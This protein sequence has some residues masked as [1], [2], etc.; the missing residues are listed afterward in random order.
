MDR[1]V[2]KNVA[3]NLNGET[4]PYDRMKL[5]TTDMWKDMSNEQIGFFCRKDYSYCSCYEISFVAHGRTKCLHDYMDLSLFQ[6]TGAPFVK[7]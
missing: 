5:I 1:L 2:Y 7:L 3:Y 4:K 6:I